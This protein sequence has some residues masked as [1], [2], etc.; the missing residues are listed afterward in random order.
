[1]AAV[2]VLT[3]ACEDAGDSTGADGD[4]PIVVGS[5]LSLTGPFGATGVIHRIAGEMF[6]E[7]LNE[8]GGLLGREVEWRRLDDE[9]DAGN[10]TQ[11]Y[12]RLINQDQVDLIIGPYATPNI[13]AAVAVAERAGYMM[14][15][16]TAIHAP[17][18][19]YECQFP[20]WSMDPAP[21]TYTSQLLFELLGSLPDPPET[22]A[23]VTN[24]SGSTQPM[25]EGFAGTDSGGGMQGLA[26]E[27][28]LEVVEAVSY[29][30]GNQE[31]GSLAVQLRDADADVVINNGLG[32]DPV[33]LIEA[34]AQLD[35]RPPMFFSL[36]PAPGPL[37]ALGEPA[38]GTLSVSLFEPN[39][40][41]IEQYGE[42]VRGIVDEFRERAEAEDLPYPAFET[43]AAASWN[44]W[45]ILAGAVEGAGTL[46]QRALC[47]YL[48]ED[49]VETTFNGHLTFDPQVSNFWPTNVGIKQIQDGDW[50]MVWPQERAAAPVAPPAG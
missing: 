20:G 31:W 33:G 43:Q 30:P 9:S 27:Y 25:T 29:A 32:V 46:D 21:D 4:G 18:L 37:L 45:E 41:L 13:L 14:P 28:G 26:P 44:A 48:I 19:A 16:H 39:G 24:D 47:D 22:I 42:E 23:L 5:S 15:H 6:V 49:G 10:V 3:A 36:F 2:L 38:E 34:M 40:P 1:M 35:Y 7:R 17:L 11:L 12:E 50:V 8:A